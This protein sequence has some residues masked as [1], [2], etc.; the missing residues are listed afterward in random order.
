MH[1]IQNYLPPLI[2]IDRPRDEIRDIEGG[3]YSKF[4]NA[5]PQCLAF[6]PSSR[7]RY[8]SSAARVAH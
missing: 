3:T 8:Y 4:S 6:A 5:D 1:E 2:G 7:N